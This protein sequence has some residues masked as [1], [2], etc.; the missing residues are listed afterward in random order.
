MNIFEYI[1]I[2]KSVILTDLNQ[3][4]FYLE[5]ISSKGHRPSANLR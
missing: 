4:Q 2:S 3:M 5:I 1:Q